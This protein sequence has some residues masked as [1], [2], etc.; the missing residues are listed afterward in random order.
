MNDKEWRYVNEAAR[1]LGGEGKVPEE[2]RDR[3]CRDVIKSM[4]E[5]YIFT[6]RV[7]AEQRGRELSFWRRKKTK[8]QFIDMAEERAAQ[9]L[10]EANLW[11]TADG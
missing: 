4:A 5:G 2:M 1:K 3:D 6:A 8:K 11:L 10:A 9:L 7:T